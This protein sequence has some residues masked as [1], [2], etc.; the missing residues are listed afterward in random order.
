M[1]IWQLAYDPRSG[2]PGHGLRT[3]AVTSSSRHPATMSSTAGSS[4]QEAFYDASE[5]LPGKSTRSAKA[6]AYGC[7]N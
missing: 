6:A 3:S 1:H 5:E 2:L 4:A 7:V